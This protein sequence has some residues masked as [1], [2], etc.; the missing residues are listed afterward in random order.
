MRKIFMWTFL[1]SLFGFGESKSQTKS[2]KISIEK[3][4]EM[5]TNMENHGVNTNKKMLWGYF[6]TSNKKDNFEKV[7]NELKN[8]NF[9]FVKIFQ[10]DDKSYWLHLERIEIH[11]SK[12]LFELNEELYKIADKYKI[13]YDGFD[14]GN[15]DKNKAIERNTYVVPEEFKAV[16]FNKENFPFLLIGNTAFDRFPHKE[17]FCYFIKITTSYEKD[18][19]A[20]LP[21]ENELEVLENFELFIENNLT[22]NKV[23]NYYV[24]RDTYKGIR[25]FYIVSNDENGAKEILKLI[26]NS[27]KQRNFD[28]EI[29]KDKT[30]NL[31][32]EFRKKMPKE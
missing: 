17:E 31:Y 16:D 6:F 21:S 19:K 13:N 29:I 2:E 8:Q 27:G 30:W 14:V 25:N 5:F 24:F 4:Q 10:A 18:G 7:T 20:M 22:Q 1:L 9:E 26:K 3:I 28:F 11:N 12:S 15:V 23:K 32:N